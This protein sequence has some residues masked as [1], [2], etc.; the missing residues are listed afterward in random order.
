M[1]F[2]DNC[3]MQK[4]FSTVELSE[5]LDKAA[6][7]S[8][9]TPFS[10]FGA[11]P[12][13]YLNLQ[14]NRHFYYRFTGKRAFF[15]TKLL[16]A[17]PFRV[18][19]PSGAD[20]YLLGIKSHDSEIRLSRHILNHVPRGTNFLDVGAHFGYYSV[21]T[22]LKNKD[23]GT[24]YALEPGNEMF[25]VLKMNCA[26]FSQIKLFNLAASDKNGTATFFDY[27]TRYN[28][29][30]S[31]KPNPAAKGLKPNEVKAKTV[32]LD[33]FFEE[34]N[35]KPDYIKIDV[36]GGEFDAIRGM[37]NYLRNESPVLIIEYFH[38][39][40]DDIYQKAVDF[41]LALGYKIHVILEDGALYEKKELSRH[42]EARGD[43]SDNIVFLK[44]K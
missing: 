21:L 14:F 37:E 25:E 28:E 41:M 19:L 42:F 22:A 34:N 3:K 27:P 2:Y 24:I 10:R 16:N 5:A 11:H 6:E 30:S 38:R 1:L 43:T 29:Y 12:L 7:L 4:Q 8:M 15:K 36:E 20:I 9:L 39:S 40:S 33:D 17:C 13:R 32:R 18:A 23:L 31:L 44:T 26:P 35:F